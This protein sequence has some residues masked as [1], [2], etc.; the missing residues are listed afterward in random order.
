[1]EQVQ[2]IIHH[3]VILILSVGST[4]LSLHPACG[5]V[6]HKAWY[7]ESPASAEPLMEGAPK[8]GRSFYTSLGHL[9]SSKSPLLP[10]PTP[11]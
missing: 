6:D 4:I 8:A 2:V 1:M 7:I 3:K 11:V 9:D 10:I 5:S